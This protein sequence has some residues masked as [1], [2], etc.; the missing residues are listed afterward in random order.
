MFKNYYLSDSFNQKETISHLKSITRN[1]T[2]ILYNQKD[3]PSTSLYLA[4]NGVNFIKVDSQEKLEQ[5]ILNNETTILL[6]SFKNH[7]LSN[8]DN[9]NNI[10]STVVMDKYPITNIIRINKK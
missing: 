6:T 3:N 1:K 8:L 9:I 4:M 5:I 10:K 2:V 7:T